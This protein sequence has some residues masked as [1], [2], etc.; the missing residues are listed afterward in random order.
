M[1]FWYRPLQGRAAAVL[2]L[3][4]QRVRSA[5]LAL[6]VLLV[7]WALPERLAPEQQVLQAQ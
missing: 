2:V 3:L 7:H 6:L 4:A 5:L 1:V